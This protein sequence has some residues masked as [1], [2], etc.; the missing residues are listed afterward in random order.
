MSWYNS[1]WPHSTLRAVSGWE[2][3]REAGLLGKLSVLPIAPSSQ[4]CS[5]RISLATSHD[6]ATCLDSHILTYSPA[7]KLQRLLAHNRF[8]F[9]LKPSPW[10]TTK[11]RTRKNGTLITKV[12]ERRNATRST[13]HTRMFT[14]MSN[15][16]TKA[17]SS[18]QTRRRVKQ[19]SPLGRLH[20]LYQLENGF[21]SK[22]SLST[23][24]RRT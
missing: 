18:S 20:H 19:T 5:L 22:G 1:S 10:T 3:G 9:D 4:A 15:T 13:T 24:V 17:I 11:E 16:K 23:R 12:L 14:R 6:N 21:H 2:Q 7:T 8:V